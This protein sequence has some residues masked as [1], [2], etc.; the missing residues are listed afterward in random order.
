MAT[1]VL[2]R[3]SKKRIVL[4]SSYV[5]RAFS[6]T[7]WTRLRI[8][9]WIACNGATV[10]STPRFAF[11]LVSGTSSIYPNS[12]HFAGIQTNST[13]WT[14]TTTNITPMSTSAST[15]L[16]LMKKVATTESYGT[17]SN[18][19]S[20]AYFLGGTTSANLNSFCGLEVEK[21]SGT[22]WTFR[23]IF[24][25]A[26]TGT[27]TE[28]TVLQVMEQPFNAFSL[29]SHAYVRAQETLTVDEATNGAM[30]AVNVSWDRS[31]PVI[32]LL[33]IYVTKLP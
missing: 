27:I 5:A 16:R 9:L 8:G 30:T 31:D 13:T 21:T 19:A 23:P 32:D 22:T 25:Q 12:C 33:G 7:G 11:G 3:H 10:T 20:G 24:S 29:T 15:R 1:Q 2:T 28:A 18:N 14:A 26:S 17:D 4:A 6:F